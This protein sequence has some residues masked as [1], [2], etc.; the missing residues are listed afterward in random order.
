MASRD[1]AWQWVFSATRQSTDRVSGERRRHHL[2]ERVLQRA[3]LEAVRAAGIAKNKIG[4]CHT[5]RHSFATQLLEDG[6]DIRTI[7]QLFGHSDV[8]TTMID[9]HIVRRAA[10]GVRSPADR[11]SGQD[12]VDTGRL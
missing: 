9:T 1:W 11:L 4:R 6:Y 12:Y 7:Q 3:L 5:L 8:R 10:L 2:H